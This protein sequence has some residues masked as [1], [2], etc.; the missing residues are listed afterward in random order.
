[1]GGKYALIDHIVPVVIECAT[2]YNITTYTE[3]CGGGGKILTN[4]PLNIFEHRIYNEINVG[5]CSLFKVLQNKLYTAELITLLE[6]YRYSEEVFTMAIRGLEL[7]KDINHLSE[8]EVATY[9]YIATFQSRAS[10]M[11]T[12]SPSKEYDMGYYHKIS[13]LKEYYFILQ[14]VDIQNQDCMVLLEEY[15][16]RQDILTYIDPPYI[17]TT[18]NAPKT[19][20]EHS[21]SIEQHRVLVDKLLQT[22]GKV[23]LSGYEDKVFNTYKPLEDAGWSK[24]LLRNVHI[25]SSIGNSRQ[26]EYIWVNFEVSPY[27]LQKVSIK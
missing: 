13:R 17:P 11:T 6:K 5:F 12:Y 3:L 20:G 27:V 23:I 14:D 18:M 4:L 7:H 16:E 22:K 24:I 25:A 8:I 2:K 10:N 21:W 9:T 1:M 19:Y 15:K 26:D